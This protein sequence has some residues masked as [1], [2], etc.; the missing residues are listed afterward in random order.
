MDRVIVFDPEEQFDD[1]KGFY[2]AV[3]LADFLRVLEDCWDG[4]FRLIYV[5]QEMHEE[6]ELHQVSRI[7]QALQE[8]Y[9]LG[10]N[11]RKVMFV[12][13]EAQDSFG[14]HVKPK[15]SG[16]GRIMSKGGK[17]GIDVVYLAQ[18]PAEVSPRAR[19]N[20]D[21]VASFALSFSNDIEAAERAM[22]VQGAGQMIQEL[23]R[24]HHVYRDENGE[25]RIIPPT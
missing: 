12:V 17:R 15:H 8:P 19:G 11:E 23:E 24:F 13:D 25:L 4:N 6:A 7:V 5:P 21:R 3:D 10:E 18:R 22:Q 2:R 9:K 20:L 14:L 16:F 1:L